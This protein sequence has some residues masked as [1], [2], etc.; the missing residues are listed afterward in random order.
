M[1]CAQDI[2]LYDFYFFQHDLF[3]IEA[4]DLGQLN[5]IKVHLEGF[6]SNPSWFID[7][8]SVRESEESAQVF[9]FEC[10]SWLSGDPPNDY[11]AEFPLSTIEDVQEEPKGSHWQHY[12]DSECVQI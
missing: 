5:K 2:V 4:V 7:K 11:T 8:V 1:Q 9:V 10:G 3:R 6:G 12:N